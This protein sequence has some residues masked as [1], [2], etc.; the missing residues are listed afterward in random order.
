M[1]FSAFIRRRRRS[2]SPIAML[3]VWGTLALGGCTGDKPAPVGSVLEYDQATDPSIEAAEEYM[4]DPTAGM[5]LEGG[6]RP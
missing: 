3:L 4:Q 1:K 5:E 6:G 2:S